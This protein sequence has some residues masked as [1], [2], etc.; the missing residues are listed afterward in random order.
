MDKPNCNTIASDFQI[1]EN[2]VITAAVWVAQASLV[3]R[4]ESVETL[5]GRDA[6]HL[7]TISDGLSRLVPALQRIGRATKSVE[8]PQAVLLSPRE[9]AGEIEEDDEHIGSIARRYMK[10]WTTERCTGGAL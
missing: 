10:E 7:R 8:P 5:S 2:P 1:H 4:Q 3:L 9:N 6:A